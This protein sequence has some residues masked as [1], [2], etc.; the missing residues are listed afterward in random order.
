MKQSPPSFDGPYGILEISSNTVHFSIFFPDDRLTSMIDE[1]VKCGL[2]N[3]PKGTLNLNPDGT[4]LALDAIALYQRN[5]MDRIHLT[6]FAAIGTGAMRDADN[7]QDFVKTLNDEFGIELDVISGED[8]SYYS[9]LGVKSAFKNADG[10]MYD[11]G[12]RSSEFAIIKNGE[13]TDCVSLPLG[14]F[15]ISEHD[16]PKA[17]IKEQ[18]KTLPDAYKDQ[19]FDNL[20]VVGGSPRR[21]LKSHRRR[22]TGLDGSVHGY[23]IPAKDARKLSKKMMDCS[24]DELRKEFYISKKRVTLVP[25]AAQLLVQITKKLD[26]D[27]ITASEH[28]LRH[29]VVHEMVEKMKNDNGLD[30]QQEPQKQLVNA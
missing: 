9:A 1:K 6:D 17:F 20:Y 14:T 18:L 5:F 4:E 22:E 25:A 28:G 7:A 8:E 10:I 2:G 3:Y 13:I 23:S 19:S 24:S 27:K 26:V 12:G 16:D 29:G 11:Q 30:A 21:I 15:S